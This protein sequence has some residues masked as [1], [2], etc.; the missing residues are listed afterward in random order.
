MI[1]AEPVRNGGHFSRL[2]VQLVVDAVDVRSD[3]ALLGEVVAQRRRRLERRTRRLQ[4]VHQFLDDRTLHL[5]PCRSFFKVQPEASSHP[6][7]PWSARTHL[8]GHKVGHGGAVGLDD[9]RIG[10]DGRVDAPQD[11]SAVVVLAAAADKNTVSRS[12]AIAYYVEDSYLAKVAAQRRRR[13]ELAAAGA[14][15]VGVLCWTTSF[16]MTFIALQSRSSLVA[17][18]APSSDQSN[19]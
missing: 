15:V 1:D 11:G 17:L 7:P 8:H 9:A 6:P 5:P 13:L 14:Q 2:D 4:R 3:G 12:S 19:D 10:F 16:K 18:L